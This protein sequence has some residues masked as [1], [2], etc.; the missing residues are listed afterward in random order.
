M[1]PEKLYFVVSGEF[2]L[3]PQHTSSKQTLGAV[4][5]SGSDIED[6]VSVGQV[7]TEVVILLKYVLFMTRE[8]PNYH[9]VL[10]EIYE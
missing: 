8:L 6:V 3:D 4:R 2:L 1:T 9:E 5:A 10:V 7:H